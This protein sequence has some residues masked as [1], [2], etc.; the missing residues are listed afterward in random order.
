MRLRAR[1][2]AA[3]AA[4]RAEAA[5]AVAELGRV[6]TE[7]DSLLA[8]LNARQ[9][10]DDAT[11]DAGLRVRLADARQRRALLEREVL[12]YR[13]GWMQGRPFAD[14]R[15]GLTDGD[16]GTVDWWTVC[17]CVV[18]ACCLA[19]VMSG[20]VWLI[21]PALAGAVGMAGAWIVEEWRST[22]DDTD[23]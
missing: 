13:S 1:Q 16:G 6:L 3:E 17:G 14:Y 19:S 10:D 20:W 18:V 23:G 7:R 4:A 21:W 5:R 22:G 8:A 2:S 9:R 12:H 11:T 15:D